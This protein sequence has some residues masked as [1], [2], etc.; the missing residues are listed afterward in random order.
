MNLKKHRGKAR[1]KKY[2]LCDSIYIINLECDK[3]EHNKVVNQKS[4]HVSTV[5]IRIVI[6]FDQWCWQAFGVLEKFYFLTW[7]VVA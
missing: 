3:L 5:N 6:T 7:T 1:R 4:K 2:I